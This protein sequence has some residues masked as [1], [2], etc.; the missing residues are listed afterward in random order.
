MTRRLG[1]VL[2]ATRSA[3]VVRAKNTNIATVSLP[4]PEE[5]D[6]EKRASKDARFFVL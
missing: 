3:H 6:H 1:D 2:P 4:D 5:Q